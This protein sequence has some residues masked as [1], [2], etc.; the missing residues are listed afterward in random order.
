MVIPFLVFLIG[1]TW[2][3]SALGAFTRD[4]AYLMMT[5]APVLMFATPVFFSIDETLAPL[6]LL[7]YLNLLTGFI[8]TIRDLMVFGGLAAPGWSSPG[9]SCCRC[10]SSGSATGSSA[11]NGSDRRCHLTTS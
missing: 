9:R 8:E 2:F 10:S 6:V 5:L 11:G 4:T 7:M 1:M 3:L